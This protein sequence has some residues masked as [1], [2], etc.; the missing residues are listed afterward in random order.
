LRVVAERLQ[1]PDPTDPALAE[2][3]VGVTFVA[4]LGDSQVA[5]VPINDLEVP[6]AHER[7][8][9]IINLDQPL[10]EGVLQSGEPLAVEVL[11]GL[12]DNGA[13][14]DRLRFSET[15]V[16]PPATWIGRHIPGRKQPWRLWYRIEPFRHTS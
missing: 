8:A 11:T 5:R 13:S 3:R 4:R 7:G 14:L 2:E 1:V 15:L 10:Y 6:G 16:G 12:D 9:V